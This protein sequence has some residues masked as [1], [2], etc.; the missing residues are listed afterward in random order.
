MGVGIMPLVSCTDTPKIH[1]RLRF[2]RAM[3]RAPRQKLFLFFF[4]TPGYS[5]VY[6]VLPSTAAALV[7]AIRPEYA[8]A[9]VIAGDSCRILGFA[10]DSCHS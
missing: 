8:C 2:V 3:A 10:G 7:G 4:F 5:V 9:V 1:K 6:S